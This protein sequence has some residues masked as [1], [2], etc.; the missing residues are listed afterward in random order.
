MVDYRFAPVRY[1]RG[2]RYR[3][4]RG[5]LLTALL[6][7]EWVKDGI[8]HAMQQVRELWWQMLVELRKR[9]WPPVMQEGYGYLRN[10]PPFGITTR[11]PARCCRRAL[12]CPFCY[13]RERVIDPLSALEM[14]LYHSFRKNAELVDPNVVLVEFE[15]VRRLAP[16]E[17]TPELRHATLI[18]YRDY[19]LPDRRL[20]VDLLRP[21]G[22]FV[23]HRLDF[24]A[25]AFPA[26]RSG[27]LVCPRPADG[28]EIIL[29][30]PAEGK[31]R[32]QVWP[33]ITKKVLAHAAARVFRYPS[34]LLL[35]PASTLIT[36]M[37]EMK[38]CQ[39][40]TRYGFMRNRNY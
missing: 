7:D 36:Y 14:A 16:P 13:I 2:C 38:D 15:T 40:L 33:E 6:G 28:D 24:E 3:A 22:G 27:L 26:Y 4:G 31:R 37:D 10:C 29:P 20:E 18:R 1:R 17:W 19:V 5:A 39:V 23:S 34:G 8:A 32:Y 21:I 35:Q 12:I 30:E 9:R 25:G 11:D